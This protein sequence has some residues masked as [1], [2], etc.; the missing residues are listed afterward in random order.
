MPFSLFSSYIY[1]SVLSVLLIN[2][3]QV[4]S[5][6]FYNNRECSLFPFSVTEVTEHVILILSYYFV[7]H[8]CDIVVSS[9]YFLEFAHVITF[10][11]L[12]SPFLLVNWEI[13][14]QVTFQLER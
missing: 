12:I 1:W 4:M 5:S 11:F 6:V 10:S 7:Y 9:F 3:I 2:N 8:V 13:C 14:R